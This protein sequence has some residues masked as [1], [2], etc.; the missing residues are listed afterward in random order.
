MRCYRRLL[1]SRDRH[2]H[3]RHTCTEC[4]DP[5]FP[6]DRYEIRAAIS[7]NGKYRYFEVEKIHIWPDCPL[8]PDELRELDQ[9]FEASQSR[10]FAL[11]A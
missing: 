2:A 10:G 4:G 1:G 8:S 9:A 7:V 6:G 5:I 11:A 3:M